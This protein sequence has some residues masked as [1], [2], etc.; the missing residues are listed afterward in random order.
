LFY[1]L[2]QKNSPLPDDA[3]DDDVHTPLIHH[4]NTIRYKDTSE[5]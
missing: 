2:L 4:C 3:F 5:G 1:S